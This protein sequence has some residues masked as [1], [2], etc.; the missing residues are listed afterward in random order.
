ME[1]TLQQLRA[2]HQPVLVALELPDEDRLVEVEEELLMPLPRDL[3]EFLLHASD[4]VYGSLE[5]VTAADPM[6][7]TYLPEVAALAWDLGLP[8]HLLPICAW[9]DDYY[10]IDPDGEVML[11]RAGELADETWTDLWQWIREVWLA[12]G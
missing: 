12:Y 9:E 8:R 4:V 7:H 11:W 5:P 1:E 6:A 10:C 2:H 3:R